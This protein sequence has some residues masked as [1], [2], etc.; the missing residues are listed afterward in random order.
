M[1]DQT[2]QEW[3]ENAWAVREENIY[4]SLFG[5]VGSGIY[6]LDSELFTG[7]FRQTSIDPRWLNHGVFE[8]RPSGTRASWLYVSS[9][10]SNAWDADSAK[11]GEVSGLGCE[12]IIESPSQS[13]WALLLLRRMVA[14]QIL[15][16]LGRFEGKGV[17][18]AWDRI[19]LRA[20]IDGVSSKLNWVWL[21]AAPNFSERQLLPSGQFQFLEFVGITEDEADFAR[22]NGGDKLLALLIQRKAAPITHPSRESVLEKS[23]G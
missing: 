18:Q 3:F 8:S 6:A 7:Q 19:P 16:S 22:N 2:W 15:L 23:E 12:F 4:R 1:A 17:L 11:P 9:G 10:L 21:I 14:F 13:E 20:P 5:D